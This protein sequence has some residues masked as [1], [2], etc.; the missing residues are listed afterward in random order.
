VTGLL[1]RTGMPAG[2]EGRR[3]RWPVLAAV[4]VL[5]LG[6]VWLIEFSSVLGV[7]TVTVSGQSRVSA[8]QITQ[9]AGIAEGAPLAR[10]DTAAVRARIARIPAIRSVVVRTSY[11]STVTIRVSER[12]AV[13]YRSVAGAVVLVDADDVAFATQSRAPSGLPQLDGTA[14]PARAAAAATVAAAFAPG[15]AR[16]VSR[17]A[18]PST[19]SVTLT[20]TDGRTILW[21]GTDRSAEKAALVPV[22]IHQPGTYFDVSDPSSVISRGA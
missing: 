8:A 22:L 18:A 15:F 12:V 21:G 9:A 2:S 4:A 20:L 1:E 17:I 3:R 13:G 5:V 14:D 10:L 7:R 16:V 6:M 19:Q 11:P